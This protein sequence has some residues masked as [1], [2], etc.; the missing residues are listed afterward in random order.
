MTAATDATTAASSVS[1]THVADV[2]NLIRW[3]QLTDVRLVGTS[4]G[5]LV[6]TGVADREPDTIVRLVYVNALVPADK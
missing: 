2:G 6:I 1:D 3:E 5:G 4:Y